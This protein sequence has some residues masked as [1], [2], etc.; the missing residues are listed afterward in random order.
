MQKKEVNILALDFDGVIA[1]SQLECFVTG[2][3]SYKKI[4]KTTRLLDNMGITKDNVY[5]LLQKHQ[6]L[7]Q[8]YTKMR[9]FVV[10]AFS[11]FVVFYALDKD[12]AIR[13]AQ[14]YF[15]LRGKLINYH[16]PYVDFFYKTRFSWIENH[17]DNW[18][19]LLSPYNHV[20][21]AINSLREHFRIAVATNNSKR[22]V[23]AFLNKFGMKP[24]L[25]I[26]KEI[27]TNKVEQIQLITKKL[28]VKYENVYFIDDNVHHLEQVK[29]TGAHCY[30]AGWGYNTKDQQLIARKENIPILEQKNFHNKLFKDAS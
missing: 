15:N 17:F 26:T 24:E 20:L 23:T 14:D 11:F 22:S 25:M 5:D 4:M 13:T 16:A 2:Y 10:D 9:P 27:T 30:L 3:T 19:S 7:Y 29:K 18:L 6:K 12:I 28:D 1:D 21:K 8:H